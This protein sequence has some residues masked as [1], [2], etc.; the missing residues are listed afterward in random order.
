[1]LR[2]NL[3]AALAISAKRSGRRLADFMERFEVMETQEQ[4]GRQV[5]PE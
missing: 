3:C 5:Q 4:R 2:V 1:M